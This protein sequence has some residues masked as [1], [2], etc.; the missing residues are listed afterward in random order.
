MRPI[1]GCCTSRDVKALPYLGLALV[2][3]VALML[4]GC[5][6]LRLPELPPEPPT[7]TGPVATPTLAPLLL[8][9]APTVTPLPISPG[10]QASPTPTF[11]LPLPDPTCVATPQ[12]GLGEVWR[13]EG[14]RTRLGCPVGDQVGVQG[15]E[16]YFQNGHMLWRPDAG[17]IY[18]LFYRQ[19]TEAWGAFVDTF[20]PTDTDRDP[21]IVEP[22]PPA[23]VQVYAQPTGRFG[24]V[25][26]E[27]PWLR[28]KL[29][30]A[31]VPY[32]GDGHPLPSISFSGAAQDFERGALLWNGGVCFVLRVDDMSWTMY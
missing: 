19:A 16:L 25:W 28:Q 27:N 26:R 11:G 9:P 12:W 7:P 6:K 21:A 17:L 14:V 31:V 22:T 23:G 4:T 30:W 13:N 2:S 20:R 24:K 29:G 5:G 15:E 18:V 3:L 10:A 8:T 32:D 1:A